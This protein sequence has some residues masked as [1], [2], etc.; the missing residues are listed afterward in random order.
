MCRVIGGAGWG[1]R[2]EK[3]SNT[4][5]LVPLKVSALVFS[6]KGWKVAR[7]RLFYSA[8]VPQ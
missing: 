1:L 5:F 8:V 6:A 2:V 4:T 3:C 7:P